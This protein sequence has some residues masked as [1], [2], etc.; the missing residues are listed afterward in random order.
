M[1]QVYTL[2]LSPLVM[3]DSPASH[4]QVEKQ[5]VPAL[6][7]LSLHLQWH[8]PPSSCPGC[9]SPQALHPPLPLPWPKSFSSISYSLF[10]YQVFIQHLQLLSLTY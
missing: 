5:I 6:P 3:E 2:R 1:A 8:K 9:T 7:V 10:L 4:N